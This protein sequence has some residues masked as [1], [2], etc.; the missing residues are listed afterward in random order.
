[1]KRILLCVLAAAWGLAAIGCS[2]PDSQQPA[3]EKE[4]GKLYK[5]YSDRFHD[6]IAKEAD[7][8][9][10]EQMAAEA[11]RLWQET[12]G[13]HKALLKQR[14][15]ELLKALDPSPAIVESAEKV[16]GQPSCTVGDKVYIEIA[17]IARDPKAIAPQGDVAKHLL[18]NPMGAAQMAL[19]NWLAVL[20]DQRAFAIRSVASNHA[21]LTWEALDKNVDRPRLVLRQGPVLFTMDLARAD[22]YYQVDKMRWLKEKSAGSVLSPEPRPPAAP[23]APV[24]PPEKPAEK[25]AETPA[26]VKSPEKPA[27]K[28]AETPATPMQ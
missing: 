26:P 27:E 6:K 14:A 10:P 19:N 17:S 2:A 3:S 21:S 13:P 9:K 20:L 5:Q 12:F 24:K 16:G 25:P 1:M 8:L 23:A 7:T 4:F 28:P 22:D 18:W 15:A 11:S